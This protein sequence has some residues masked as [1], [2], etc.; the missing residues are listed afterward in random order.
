MNDISEKVVE[1]K[2]KISEAVKKTLWGI[3]LQQR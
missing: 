3:K 1:H 2:R